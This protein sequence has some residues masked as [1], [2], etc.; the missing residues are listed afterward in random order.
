MSQ[1]TQAYDAVELADS[2][3]AGSSVLTVGS[4]AFV[5]SEPRV[6]QTTISFELRHTLDVPVHFHPTG[7]FDIIQ[8]MAAA[9]L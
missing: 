2:I 5:I 8:P 1:Y 7:T 6:V 3:L 4:S 9:L